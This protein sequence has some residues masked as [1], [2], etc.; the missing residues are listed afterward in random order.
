[1]GVANKHSLYQSPT[2]KRIGQWLSQPNINE[3]EA[4]Q[5]VARACAE[6]QS[7]WSAQEEKKR[8]RW[9]L[10]AEPTTREFESQQFRAAVLFAAR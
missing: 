9:S 4:G 6:I 2:D 3:E 10:G 7:T 1:M 5:Y 8:R